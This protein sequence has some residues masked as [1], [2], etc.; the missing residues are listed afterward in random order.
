M[1]FTKVAEVESLVAVDLKENRRKEIRSG[2]SVRLLLLVYCKGQGEHWGN[3]WK[4]TQTKGSYLI[5]LFL[6]W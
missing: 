3:T 4:G 5:Y 6:I 1:T 2:K